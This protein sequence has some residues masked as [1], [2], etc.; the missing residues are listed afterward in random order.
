MTENAREILINATRVNPAH[1]TD[2]YEFVL[3][4]SLYVIECVRV[5]SLA[6][7]IIYPVNNYLLDLKNV[8]FELNH[9]RVNPRV[10]NTEIIE[11]LTQRLEAIGV[12]VI[13]PPSQESMAM[14][15]RPLGEITENVRFYF[16]ESGNVIFL[17]PNAKLR[18]IQA[19]KSENVHPIKK[20][21]DQPMK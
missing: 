12:E 5:E 1:T 19:V 15:Y 9:V 6:E 11:N 3:N 8:L 4:D 7:G 10:D 2:L 16:N 13:N 14:C 20:Q 21:P 18:A 17:C